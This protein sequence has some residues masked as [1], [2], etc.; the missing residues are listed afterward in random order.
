MPV[1]RKAGLSAFL[2]LRKVDYSSGFEKGRRGRRN[3]ED[4]CGRGSRQEIL[5]FSDH[6]SVETRRRSTKKGKKRKQKKHRN[7]TRQIDSMGCMTLRSTK[8][9][10]KGEKRSHKRQKN[11]CPKRNTRERNQKK[12]KKKKR[13][14]NTDTKNNPKTKNQHNPK[15]EMRITSSKCSQRNQGLS[16]KGNKRGGGVAGN[17]ETYGTR[18]VL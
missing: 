4:S 15:G 9:T 7:R 12:K 5:L 2:R 11:T 8:N 17:R 14:V 13:S 18:V 10:T 6:K 16:Q 1:P 3:E